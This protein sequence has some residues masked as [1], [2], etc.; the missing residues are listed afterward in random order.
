MNPVRI[1]PRGAVAVV[2]SGVLGVAA[3]AWP[4]LIDPGSG[5]AHGG[6]AP[7]TFALL[8]P[9]ALV[10]VLAEV[11]EGGMDAKAVAML[12]VLS[13]LGAAVRTVGAGTAGVETVFFLIVLAGRVFGPGFGWVLGNTTLFASALLTSGVGP[14]LPYQMLGAAWVGM[15]AGLL[16]R[17]RGRVELVLLAAYGMVASLLYGMLL[18]LS[19]WP[20]AVGA[21][22]A[23][24]F[25]PGDPVTDNLARLVTFSLATSLGWD[26]GR[27]LTTVVLVLATGTVL[28]RVFRRA[29]RRATWL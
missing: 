9:L 22:T 21:G 29:A 2:L 18:N 28:L 20:F 4:L 10:V 1:G 6:D 5:L 19:F 13:A 15:A 26:I 8:L 24:S 17:A 7:L 12:G 25:V 27:A 14:W 3:F 11:S 16:P 23:V